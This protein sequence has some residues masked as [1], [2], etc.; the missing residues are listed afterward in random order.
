[1]KSLWIDLSTNLENSNQIIMSK[2]Y[3]VS[4]LTIIVAHMYH[5]NY[6]G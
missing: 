1:M 6:W 5:M 3:K 2:N 4:T